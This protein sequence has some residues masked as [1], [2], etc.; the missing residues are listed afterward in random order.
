MYVF[1]EVGILVAIAALMAL[2]MRALRQPLI[3]G[4]I[5]TGLVVGPFVFDIIRSAETLRLFSQL[6]V[7]FLLFIVGLS[8]SPR[9]IKEIGRVAVLTGVGQVA[10][11]SFAGYWVGIW[12]GFSPLTSLYI[13]VALSFSST[14]IILKLISD[15]GDLDNL[16]AKISIGFLLV[17]DLIA[18]ALIFVIPLLSQR[19]G[20]WE[21]V[22][23]LIFKGIFVTAGLLVAS[24]YLL[25]RLHFFFGRSQELLF[26]FAN[27]WGMGIAALFLQLGF[28]LE[29]GAL[30]A[31]VALSNLPSRREISSR[32]SPLRDFFIVIFFILLG[33]QLVV[34]DLSGMAYPIIIFSLL[35]LVGNPIILMAIMGAM[36]YRK[37]TSFNTGVTVA[38]I[39]EFSLI[40]VA[41]GVALGQVEARVLSLVTL[42][43]LVTIFGS[44]YLILY[45]DEIRR[46][47]TGFLSIFERGSL[48]AE[49]AG[50][51]EYEV[52]LFGYNRIGYD[53]LEVFKRSGKSFI[54]IDYD[55]QVIRELS[56][57]GVNSLYGDASDADFINSLNLSSVR[58][59][60]STIPDLETNLL[61]LRE[62]RAKNPAII[63]LAV[64]HRINEAEA[65]YG[66]GVNFVIMPHFLGGKYA[67]KIVESYWYDSGKFESLRREHLASL[68]SR[69]AAGQEHPPVEKH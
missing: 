23:L 47:I 46:R 64:A 31:G 24:H 52:A 59:A 37:S 1:A 26:L 61:L 33:S 69:L 29:G 6:G 45:S 41:L 57:R 63:F 51:R 18:V 27:A 60:V 56:G 66:A 54:V 14:I 16:Y 30:I 21:A 43:G 42:V 38:Q 28:P 68:S 22:V 7:A 4:H 5:L 35:V 36:G 11:T 48:I 62:L 12:L 20:S 34:G 49:T 53:F 17:Q 3:I 13:A 44:T 40:L 9:V 65:L 39:S 50:G 55:P 25:P 8:L 2:A 19:Q 32:L 58:L 10:V 15:K 67:S